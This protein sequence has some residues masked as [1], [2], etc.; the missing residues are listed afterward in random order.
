M[1]ARRQAVR[2]IGQPIGHPIGRTL[3]H[4]VEGLI[5][6]LL[7]P[8]IALPIGGMLDRPLGR[9]LGRLIGRP[10]GRPLGRPIHRAL[11]LTIRLAVGLGACASACH[12]TVRPAPL[13]AE[14]APAP[15]P[16]PTASSPSS[17]ASPSSAGAG[18]VPVGGAGSRLQLTLGLAEERTGREL[19]LAVPLLRL[20]LRTLGPTALEVPR[21][22][23]DLLLSLRVHLVPLGGGRKEEVRRVRAFLA[24]PVALEPLPVGEAR[25]Q[26]LSPLSQEQR[27]VPLV[28]GRYQARVCVIPHGEALVPSAFTERFGGSCSNPLELTVSRR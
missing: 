6:R 22:G 8:L 12:E 15:A 1:R 5:D 28:P 9:P 16:S 26:L 11:G 10:L 18:R 3:A 4:P 19:H 2:P 21:P 17:L 7:G 13:L 27:D 20:E 14:A 24:W 25:V 23:M